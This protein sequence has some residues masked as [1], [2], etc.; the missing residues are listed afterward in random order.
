M[1]VKKT[2]ARRGRERRASERADAR[3]SMR[4]DAAA[5]AG[6]TRIVTESQN[7]S[8]S[9]VYCHASHYLA[10]LSKVQLTIVLPKSPGGAGGPQELV[11][12]DGI[13]V[14]CN[15]RPGGRS[16]T[17]YD[18]ACMFTSLEGSLRSRIEEFVTWR[19]LQALRAALAETPA[20]ERRKS[21]RVVAAARVAVKQKATARPA[22]KKRAGAR[23]TSSTKSAK[24]ASARPRRP[25]S[26][27]RAG[28][29]GR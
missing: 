6:A 13:V 26:A 22:A 21:V 12:C 3:L 5:M 4:V 17:P 10:P 24:K 9:G 8:G 27:P 1:A 18:L 25:S 16:E 2:S 15:Q 19:N 7:I 29:S 23:T 14:R 20:S 28:R 11:K